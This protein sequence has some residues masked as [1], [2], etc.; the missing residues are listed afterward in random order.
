MNKRR[1][2]FFDTNIIAQQ[3]ITIGMLLWFFKNEINNCEILLVEISLGLIRSSKTTVLLHSS[4]PPFLR[5]SGIVAF[6][7]LS[8]LFLLH[9]SYCLLRYSFLKFSVWWLKFLL[10]ENELTSTPPPPPDSAYRICYN[11]ANYGWISD[12]KMSI[13][14]GSR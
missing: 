10:H 14:I 7:L 3:C 5:S 11:M 13:D 12:F 9:L 2:S 4:V 8:L 1:N 6:I